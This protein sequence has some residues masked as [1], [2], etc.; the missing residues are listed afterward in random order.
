MPHGMKQAVWNRSF[1]LERATRSHPPLAKLVAPQLNSTQLTEI[2]ETSRWLRVEATFHADSSSLASIIQA[3][4][5]SN[6]C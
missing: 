2:V 6:A 4:I 5:Q 3:R 1:R